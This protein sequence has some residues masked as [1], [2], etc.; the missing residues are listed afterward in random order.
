VTTYHSPVL[1]DAVRAA[2]QGTRRAVDATLGD[3]GHAGMLR[4]LGA[5]VLGIDRDPEA[6]ARARG[7]LGEDGCSSPP[8][9]PIPG[10]S[11]VPCFASFILLDLESRPPSSMTG[12]GSPFAAAP[13]T[14]G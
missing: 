13:S 5:E 8:A 14:C 9:T 10:P 7:R 1:L 11:G 6:I 4:E 2:A 12:V 3:G